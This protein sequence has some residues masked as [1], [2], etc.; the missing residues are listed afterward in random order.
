MLPSQVLYVHTHTAPSTA[1]HSTAQHKLTNETISALLQHCT[2]AAPA[3]ALTPAAA[4]ALALSSILFALTAAL[5]VGVDSGLP[6]SLRT[7]PTQ[8]VPALAPSPPGVLHEAQIAHGLTQ[9][10]TV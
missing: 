5:P 2:E 3:P 6:R 1:Q 7:L 4:T 9:D 10:S 8:S